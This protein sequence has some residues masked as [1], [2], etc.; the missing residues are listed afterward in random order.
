MFS[1]TME[2]HKG[3]SQDSSALVRPKTR[4]DDDNDDCPFSQL[5]VTSHNARLARASLT[6]SSATSSRNAVCRT[7]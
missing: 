6:I 2:K 4:D 5:T 3:R 7:H 1:I